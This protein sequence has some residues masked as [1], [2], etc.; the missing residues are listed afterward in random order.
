MDNTQRQGR[1]VKLS[2]AE[3]RHDLFAYT[4]DGWSAWRVA[5]NMIYT[6]AAELPLAVPARSTASRTLAAVAASVR[7]L[8]CLVRGRRVDVVVKTARSAL[9]MQIGEQYRDVYF[10]GLLDQISHFKLEEINTREFDR[11]ARRVLFPSHLDPV[12][13]TF[14]G[15]VLGRIFPAPADDFARKAVAVLA[16]E[17]GVRIPVEVLLMRISTA[18]WQGRL[19]GLLLRRTRPKVVL[20]SDTGDYGLMIACTKAAVPVVELQHGIF[21]AAHPDAIPAKASGSNRQLL[22]AD[23]LASR[24]TYWTSALSGTRNGTVAVPVGNELVDRAVEQRRRWIADRAAKVDACVL[25][26]TSQGLDSTR[27]AQWL[28]QMMAAAPPTMQVRLL[29]KLHP[30]YDAATTA[31]DELSRDPRVSIMPGN[32]PGNVFEL[33]AEADA[34]LSIAS[35]CHFDAIAIGLPSIVVP[36]SGHEIVLDAVDG[37]S[38]ILAHAPGDVWKRTFKAPPAERSKAFAE[39]QFVGNMNR[40]INSLAVRDA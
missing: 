40:L 19:Y 6:A 8:L 17:V 14:W 27:L 28:S 33:L 34:H 20:V 22:V 36:L 39:P 9:R 16:D 7:F 26:A 12:V 2:E 35:A 4:I 13:F 38:L 30:V 32:A 24:G 5:R 15:K 1:L 31:F 18:Y 23:A 25:V 10:D 37:E 21:D 11:Q 3:I 29:V